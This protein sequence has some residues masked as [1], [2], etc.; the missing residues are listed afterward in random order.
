MP[1]GA[2]GVN[3]ELT[4]AHDTGK[5]TFIVCENPSSLGPFKKMAT[6]FF[7]SVEEALSTFKELGWIPQEGEGGNG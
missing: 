5:Q 7:S 6:R 2:W 4:H 1:A 3:A